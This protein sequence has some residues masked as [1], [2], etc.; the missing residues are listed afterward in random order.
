[1]STQAPA[2]GNK[3][4]QPPWVIDERG[5]IDD[6]HTAEDTG[7][8]DSTEHSASIILPT[9]YLQVET[10]ILAGELLVKYA[11]QYYLSDERALPD[12][13]PLLEPVL[14]DEE[15]P[16]DLIGAV[17]PGHPGKESGVAASISISSPPREVL[18]S[19]YSE[20]ADSV[21]QSWGSDDARQ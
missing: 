4:K 15:P 9:D 5:S 13:Q 14:P 2:T 6:P 11:E 18:Q 12:H 7:P 20:D 8:D 1:M 19:R 21:R 3:E 10:A 17:F 16:E